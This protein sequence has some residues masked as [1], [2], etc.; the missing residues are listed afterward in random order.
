[1]KGSFRL[2][3]L[4]VMIMGEISPERVRA[5]VEY[6]LKKEFKACMLMAHLVNEA[7]HEKLETKITALSNHEKMTWLNTQI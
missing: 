1:M 6:F 2:L 3:C 7:A 5:L 4:L